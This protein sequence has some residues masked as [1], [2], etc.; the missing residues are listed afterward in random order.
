M[1]ARGSMVAI[2]SF[3][4][5]S[6]G[7]IHPEKSDQS[8]STEMHENSALNEMAFL[9]LIHTVQEV[10]PHLKNSMSYQNNRGSLIA[11]YQ[12]KYLHRLYIKFG[13]SIN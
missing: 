8:N 4:S 7:N 11:M 2:K 3:F 13:T 12:S 9:P 1:I 10:L 6:W 5:V